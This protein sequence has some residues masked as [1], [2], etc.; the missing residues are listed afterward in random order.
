MK[1]SWIFAGLAA[2]LALVRSGF[3]QSERSLVGTWKLVSASSSA[4]KAVFGQNPTGFLIYTPD[5]HMSAL[6]AHDGRKPLSE[7]D[8]FSAS[9]E[10]K[11][12]AF[13]TFTAYAGRYTFTGNRVIHHVEVASLQNWANTNLTR[14]VTF[15]DNRIILRTPPM[16]SGGVSQTFELVWER[17]QCRICSPLHIES[18]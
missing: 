7:N 16:T 11:A 10:E 9:V 6:V 4:D 15:E 1:S 17:V 13:S 5:G 2:I 3:A 18:N 14:D 8:I 12:Q